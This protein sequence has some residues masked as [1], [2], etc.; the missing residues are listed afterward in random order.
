MPLRDDD[1]QRMYSTVIANLPSR[2]KIFDATSTATAYT[3]TSGLKQDEFSTNVQF[4]GVQRW[5]DETNEVYV[6]IQIWQAKIPKFVN[7]A[8]PTTENDYSTGDQFWALG[9]VFRVESVETPTSWQLYKLVNLRWSAVA[10]ATALNKTYTFSGEAP[11]D[12]LQDQA[13][14]DITTEGGEPIFL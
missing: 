8:I 13:G 6:P 3:S 1:L 11:F 9:Y 12:T 10:T 5:Y 7:P 14:L 4:Q 2:A